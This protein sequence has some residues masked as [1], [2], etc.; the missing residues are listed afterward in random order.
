MRLALTIK[1]SIHD[2]AVDEVGDLAAS[3]SA[4]FD[5]AADFIIA[6]HRV[7]GHF[8]PG[9]LP[10][11]RSCLIDA[12]EEAKSYLAIGPVIQRV[13]E[14]GFQR[15]STLVVIG[16]GVV[17]DIGCFIA[18]N[19]M[20]GVRWIYYPTTL[21]A[22]CDSCIG[23]KS[24][25]NIDRFKNQLGT[26][27]PPHAVRMYFPFLDTL[28]QGD[29]LSGLGEAIKLHL[30]AGEAEFQNLSA[31][32]PRLEG[33]WSV[34]E[35]VIASSLR[36]KQRYIEEDEFDRG[37]RNLLNYGH[38]FA[39][40]YESATHYAIPHGVAVTMGVA[41]AT[42]LSEQLEFVPAGSFAALVPVLRPFYADFLAVLRSSSPGMVLAAMKLDK[43]NTGAGVT[44]ILTRGPGKMFKHS[45]SLETISPALPAIFHDL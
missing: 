19:L 31:L 13:L 16:G 44:F 25:V 41:S 2:Y 22:Q 11:E 36:I 29:R 4:D 5:P 20:R 6:D 15:R 33:E 43:K 32:M 14:A 7:A 9:L 30:I 45:L 34:I 23:A 39:H 10:P 27:Y 40:A 17:Q 8:P 1:S 12:S 38:T 3:L 37:V 26:F 35:Q 28:P 21:L 18:S 24:S 42:W